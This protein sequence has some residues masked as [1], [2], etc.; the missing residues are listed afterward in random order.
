MKKF[1]YN[2]T[3]GNP[4]ALI[5]PSIVSF[6]EGFFKL[7]P[8]GIILDIV[9]TIYISFAN[10]I[11]MNTARLWMDSGVLIA[12][13]FVQYFMSSIAYNKTYFAAYDLS[14]KGRIKLGEHLRKLSLGF[15]G[16]RDPGDL[17]T[18][19]LGDY[20][21]VEKVISHFVPQLI[22][23]IVLPFVALV[24]LLFVDWRMAL[25]MFAALPIT[26]I[27][28]FSTNKF[29][30]KFSNKHFEAKIDAASRLQEYLLGMREIKAHSLSGDRFKRLKTAFK[31]LMK[32]SIRIEAGVG[33]VMIT[34]VAL[35]R[36]SFTI[37]I[38]VGSYALVG[39]TLTLPIFLVFLLIATRIYEPMTLVLINFAELKY[40][41]LSAERIMDIQKEK[42]LSGAKVKKNVAGRIKFENVTFA[43]QE[44]NVLK[45]VSFTIPPKSVTAL[46]GPSGSGKSTV[47]RLIARF[48]DV[49]E[50][51]VLLDN[52]D[53]KTLQP[54]KYLENVSMVF[55]DVY[56]FKDTIGNN[57]RV[58][59]QNATQ[60]EIVW[61]A[62]Q[63][64]CHDFI[65][66]L[67]LGYD[68]P[69]GEGGCTLSGGERQRVSIA[70]ALLKDA[71]IVLLDEATASLDSENELQVQRAINTLVRNKTVVIIAHRLKTIRHA[72]N[73]IVLEDGNVVEQGHHKELLAKGGLY[74]KLWKL[75]IES[76]GWTMKTA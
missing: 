16:S 23:A 57:I 65:S 22:S 31:K 15:L 2:I 34:A 1:F 13:L 70:R 40:A 56:L 66:K 74:A 51:R 73:I 27:I 14:A 64:R 47:A 24:C 63:A 55:Q 32:E 68:T 76:I 44:E 72:D 29:Q 37:M 49:Q 3:S 58:G 45:N 17:T 48:W 41:S 25:A 10:G 75:Q 52:T 35:L 46:V 38:L 26:L 62:Q 9:N 21:N 33:S 18:M 30:R 60:E 4:K 8:A 36:A 53:I 42:P 69:I 59:K 28:V 12:W 54:E 71:P 19:I 61:A 20:A 43:Y 6:F 11:P 50:G 67:P 5:V 7:V 39:G